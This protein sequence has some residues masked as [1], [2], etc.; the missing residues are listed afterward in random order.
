V[1]EVVAEIVRRATDSGL[2]ASGIGDDVEDLLEAWRNIAADAED[3]ATTLGFTL[4]G[5]A[6]R[7]LLHEVLD[8]NLDRLSDDEKR[9]RAPR[10]M[11]G[12]EA[13]VRL[14]VQGPYKEWLE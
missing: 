4:R 9:F 2:D 7:K 13:A 1:P 11:R 5:G 12:V 8:S 10:S 14:R 3:N 6:N